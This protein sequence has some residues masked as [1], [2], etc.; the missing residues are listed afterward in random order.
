MHRNLVV[1]LSE[2]LNTH[3][4]QRKLWANEQDLFVVS[5][6]PTVVIDILVLDRHANIQKDIL[7]IIMSND[8]SQR[9]PTMQSSN[10]KIS[11]FIINTALYEDNV[12]ISLQ[13]VVQTSISVPRLVYPVSGWCKV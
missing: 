9:I 8:F 3:I 12:R 5:N 10:Q 2:W 7:T 1:I 4:S 11:A 13:E 6:D